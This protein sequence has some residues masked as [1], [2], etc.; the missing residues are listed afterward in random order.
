MPAHPVLVAPDL[1][2]SRVLLQCEGCGTKLS[3]LSVVAAGEVSVPGLHFLCSIALLKL[4]CLG[5]L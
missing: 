1:S 5:Q 4:T 3:Q 2:Q